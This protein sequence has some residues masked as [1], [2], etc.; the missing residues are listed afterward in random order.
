VARTRYHDDVDAEFD[1]GKV[2]SDEEDEYV[3]EPGFAEYFDQVSPSPFVVSFSGEVSS[4][5]RLSATLE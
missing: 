2:E 4:G 3:S 5:I 1:P